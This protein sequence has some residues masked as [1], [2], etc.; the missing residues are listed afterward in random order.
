M[1]YNVST[2]LKEPVGST[3]E[4]EVEGQVLIEHGEPESCAVTGHTTFLRTRHGVLVTAQL[5]GVQHELCSRCLREMGVPMR[6]EI[7]EEFF[8]SVSVDTGAALPPPED[9]EAFRIDPHQ[10][11]DLDEAVR[12]FWTAPLPVQPLCRP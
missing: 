6:V 5:H 12:Q 4:Y 3:R 11:L 2:L 1:Q 9:P 7:E 10:T 8:S